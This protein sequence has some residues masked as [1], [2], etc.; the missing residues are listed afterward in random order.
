MDFKNDNNSFNIFVTSNANL[1]MYPDNEASKFTNVLKQTI[2]QNPNVDYQARLANFHIPSVE[3][4]LKKG[5]FEGSSLKYHISLFEYDPSTR[6][7]LKHEKYR[8]ELFR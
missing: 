5:D 8:R 1:E 3:Y 2:K 6:G 4:V 7:Y